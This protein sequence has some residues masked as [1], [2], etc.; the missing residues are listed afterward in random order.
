MYYE[1]KTP[2]PPYF[3]WASITG[4]DHYKWE[5]DY[6]SSFNPTDVYYWNSVPEADLQLPKEIQAFKLR[7]LISASHPAP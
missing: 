5:C 4:A 3:N 1:Q 6:V 7:A 2:P